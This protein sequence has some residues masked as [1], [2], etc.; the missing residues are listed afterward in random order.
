M[1][2][3]IERFPDD[4]VVSVVHTKLEY[5]PVMVFEKSAFKTRAIGGDDVSPDRSG[6]S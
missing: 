4:M 5:P 3:Y 1:L 2:A 6:I